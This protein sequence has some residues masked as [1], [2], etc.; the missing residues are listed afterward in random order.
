IQW[1]YETIKK[2]QPEPPKKINPPPVKDLNKLSKLTTE[3]DIIGIQEWAQ[4]ILE[5]NSEYNTF[6]KHILEL[7]H[8]LQLQRIQELLSQLS[9]EQL[10]SKENDK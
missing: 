6:G 5:N 8:Q 2:S 10:A 3:G 7:A 9:S 4:K 1:E